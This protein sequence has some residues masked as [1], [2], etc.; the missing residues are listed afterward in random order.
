[1]GHTRGHVPTAGTEKWQN[2]TRVASNARETFAS[3]GNAHW[4]G[5]AKYRRPQICM[6]SRC[7]RHTF[8]LD[9]HDNMTCIRL[10]LLCSTLALSN[11]C[12]ARPGRLWRRGARLLWGLVLA[13]EN[14]RMEQFF[15]R[16]RAGAL[17]GARS[18]PC[19]QRAPHCLTGR[20]CSQA[21]LVARHWNRVLQRALLDSNGL[22]ELA[23]I[24]RQR[25]DTRRSG[26]RHCLMRYAQGLTGTVIAKKNGLASARP[27]FVS[28]AISST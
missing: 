6:T 15:L 4:R 13:H 7:V 17:H 19:S 12:L 20:P 8:I 22:P 14:D 16:V 21:L 10:C 25:H 26:A 9:R 28:A 3:N 1:M 11:T 23:G 27:F 24:S 5:S 2:A 18:R